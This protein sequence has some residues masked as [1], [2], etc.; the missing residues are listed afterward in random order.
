MMRD[1]RKPTGAIALRVEVDALV[2]KVVKTNIEL[3][4]MWRVNPAVIIND[5]ISD[6]S[7]KLADEP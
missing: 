7:G 2:E 6:E 5:T 3:A 1:G 4:R